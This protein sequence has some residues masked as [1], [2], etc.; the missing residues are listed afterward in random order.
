M[1]RILVWLMVGA[2]IVMLLAITAAP[3]VAVLDGVLGG[4]F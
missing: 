2:L 4:G 3:A 1:K